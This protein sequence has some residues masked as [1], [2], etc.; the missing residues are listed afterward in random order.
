MQGITPITHR[1]GTVV[2]RVRFRLT[3]GANPVS[4][5][6]PSPEAAIEFRELVAQVGGTRARAIL[7]QQETHDYGAL[8]LEEALDQYCTHA[9]T[10]AARGTTTEYRRVAERTWLKIIPPQT[11]IVAITRQDIEQYVAWQRTQPSHTRKG[12]PVSAKT[13]RNAHG[14]LSSVLQYQV[15]LG[16]LD[17]NPARGIKIPRDQTTTPRRFLTP[18][19]VDKIATAT[20]DYALFVRFLYVTGVRFGEATAL[21]PNDFDPQARVV[22]VTKSWKRDKNSNGRY[23]GAPKTARGIRDITLPA[24]IIPELKRAI[25]PLAPDHYVFHAPSTP[26]KPV[27]Y[28]HFRA[29]I[30]A[31]ACHATGIHARIHDLRHSHASRLIQAGI[32]LPVI[33]DRLGHESIQTTVNIY[34]HITPQQAAAAATIFD[35]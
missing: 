13:I 35:Q 4:E 28:N 27:D 19:E 18:G 30:W 22:H 24:S 12:Q 6:F 25:N 7:D 26:T 8:T 15:T 11:P 34:G 29:R 3:P 5:T 20:G 9:D 31:P 21:T 16:V 14:V 32:P 23:L 2:Y 1:D 17:H 33:Q 10:Y